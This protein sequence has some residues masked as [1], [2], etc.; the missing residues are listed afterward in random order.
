MIPNIATSSAANR[1]ASFHEDTNEPPNID[2]G[3]AVFFETAQVS[4]VPEGESLERGLVQPDHSLSFIDTAEASDLNTGPV[5]NDQQFNDIPKEMDSNIEFNIPEGNLKSPKNQTHPYN[6]ILFQSVLTAEIS[7]Y[8]PVS[9]E[10]PEPALLE[11]DP[12]HHPAISGSER[13]NSDQSQRATNA[14]AQFPL[15]RADSIN[16]DANSAVF[17]QPKDGDAGTHPAPVGLAHSNP[18]TSQGPPSN[19]AVL[20]PSGSA[21]PPAIAIASVVVNEAKDSIELTLDPPELG[22]VRIKFSDD[23]MGS[24]TALVSGERAETQTMLRNQSHLLSSLLQEHGLGE[25]EITFSDWAENSNSS[26]EQKR[27][28]LAEEPSEATPLV[29]AHPS[30]KL[31]RYLKNGLDLR[32]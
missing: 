11:G 27:S 15:V 32:I 18:S 14:N 8:G 12:A 25:S 7:E 20:Q 22:K 4:S 5:K 17:S 30:A 24:V 1:E 26:S 29:A 19:Y 6:A 2:G 28:H 10:P 23:G 31:T 16:N 3:A 13:L 21:H 9:P